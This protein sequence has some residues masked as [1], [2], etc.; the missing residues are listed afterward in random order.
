MNHLLSD[1]KLKRIFKEI[2]TNLLIISHF[3]LFSFSLFATQEEGKSQLELMVPSAPVASSLSAAS[4][5]TGAVDEKPWRWS[6]IGAG[7]AGI[8][9]IGKLLDAGCDP[10]SILW[11]DPT[12]AVGDLG[13]KWS[14]V[15]GNTSVAGFL[16]FFNSCRAFGFQEHDPDLFIKHCKPSEDLKLL[17]V[18]EPLRQITGRLQEKV[19]CYQ[20]SVTEIHH[21][22]SYWDVKTSSATFKAKRVI[23]AIGSEPKQLKIDGYDGQTI[24]LEKALTPALLHEACDESDTVAVFGSSHSAVVAMYSLI[25]RKVK[26]VINFYQSPCLYRGR[27]LYDFKGLAGYSAEWAQKN[28]EGTGPDNLERILI[29]DAAFKEKLAQCNKAIYAIGFE[30]RSS[31]KIFPYG[32]VPYDS[33]LGILARGLFGIGIAFPDLRTDSLGIQEYAI[34]A[35]AFSTH[36]D[37]VLP[38]WSHY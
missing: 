12:F 6:V 37:K 13:Q 9:T 29:S 5:F 38:I 24:P 27:N 33:K 4:L 16:W 20:E 35:P 17:H 26:R 1:L 2:G 31:P 23:L 30:R 25:D 11:I 15:R 32:D 28:L 3:I 34:G 22:G 7:V 8:T 19:I 14:E 18:V 21:K 10:K 36:L